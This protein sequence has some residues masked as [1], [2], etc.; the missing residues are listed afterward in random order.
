MKKNESKTQERQGEQERVKKKSQFEFYSEKKKFQIFIPSPTPLNERR[1]F[2]EKI[3]V[4]LFSLPKSSRRR[5]KKKETKNIRRKFNQ[6]ILPEPN[7]V[8]EPKKK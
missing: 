8:F 2:G 4:V 3:P 5:W 7:L 1:D 6:F